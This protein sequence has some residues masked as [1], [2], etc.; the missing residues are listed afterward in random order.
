PAGGALARYRKRFAA[1]FRDCHRG[2][3]DFRFAAEHCSVAYVLCLDR[4]ERRSTS[5]TGRFFRGLMKTKGT[6]S[7]IRLGIPW[8]Q[9]HKGI[10]L[11]RLSHTGQAE[12]LGRGENTG[13][14]R[15]RLR[16]D[17]GHGVSSTER[18]RLGTE[19]SVP[20]FSQNLATTNCHRREI[21]A[22]ED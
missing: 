4:T 14:R 16:G 1:A 5:R 11:V 2:R 18:A 21:S 6:V 19:S 7:E 13:G 3:A 12:A 20:A 15:L 10:G 9:G 8:R 22:L 17:G